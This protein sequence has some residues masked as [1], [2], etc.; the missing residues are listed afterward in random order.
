MFTKPEKL[1]ITIGMMKLLT[2][3]DK[4]KALKALHECNTKIL[5]PFLTKNGPIKFHLRGIDSFSEDYSK[6]RV[7]FS[8]IVQENGQNHKEMQQIVDEVFDYFV[9]NELMV[10]EKRSKS[11][12]MHMTLM[13]TRYYCQQSKQKLRHFNASNIVQELSDFD[14]GSINLEELH[15]S[16]L[17]DVAE[18]G[19]YGTLNQSLFQSE[20]HSL[21]QKF[22]GLIDNI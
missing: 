8:K 10:P 18:D 4:M 22:E 12:Q 11:V 1:H 17:T 6:V 14:F 2:N 7:L 13:N 16:S 9:R 3:D 20:P 5:D 19:Y 15:L 21:T